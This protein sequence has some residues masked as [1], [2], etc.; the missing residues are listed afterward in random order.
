MRG[1]V[2]LLIL[3]FVAQS[4]FA[5]TTAIVYFDFNSAV[6]KREARNT[7]DKIAASKVLNSVGLFGHTDQVGTDEQ[8]EWLSL[9]RARVVRDYLLKKNFPAN[10]FSVVLGF[11]ATRIIADGPDEMS[12]QLNRRVVI[13]NA[14][15]PTRLD[16]DIAAQQAAITT[17]PTETIAQKPIVEKP[18]PAKIITPIAT[19]KADPSVKKDEPV[20]KQQKNEK[21]VE[22]IRDKSTLAGEHIVLKNINFHPGKS[23]FLEVAIPS[24][25]GLVEAMQSIKTLKI[26]IQGHVCCTDDNTDAL[27][28][29]TGIHNLSV[30]R[31][32]AV[33]DYLV[34][35]GIEESR[36]SFKGLAHQYPLVKV[37]ATEQDRIANRRVEI[38]ILSK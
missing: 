6:L 24:L 26:E 10:K 22:D 27:D 38:K 32:K 31:A 15:K 14:Y 13:M 30:T 20:V 5:Q 23:Y 25:Q 21:L 35:K 11:G 12:R 37:E 28:V 29:A 36:I 34:Q 16:A 9:E 18:L 19:S 8:N 4:A 3:I 33:Y 2:F 17:R 1:S 7:L